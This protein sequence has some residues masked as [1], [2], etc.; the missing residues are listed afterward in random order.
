MA[1]KFFSTSMS[2]IRRY[3][4]LSMHSVSAA[5]SSQILNQPLASEKLLCLAAAPPCLLT[6]IPLC[7]R[8][9]TLSVIVPAVGTTL[10]HQA[11]TCMC[12]AMQLTYIR[13][14]TAP[15]G[16]VDTGPKGRHDY[17]EAMKAAAEGSLSDATSMP[18]L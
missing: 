5:S 2:S 6:I 4:M 7:A 17:E 1:A 9:A 8:G 16:V 15:P 12:V 13:A 3:A 10:Q 18:A 14:H 11:Y